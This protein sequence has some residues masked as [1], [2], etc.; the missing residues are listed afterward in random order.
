MK[1]LRLLVAD[2]Q[3]LMRAGICSLL[4]A[5]PDV[6]VVGEAS[7]GHEALRLIKTLQPDIVLMDAGM[8][9]MNG[10]E[11]TALTKKRFPCVKVIILSERANDEFLF[12]ALRAGAEGF[13]LKNDSVL[14]LHT[15][16]QS[17]ARGL[18]HLSPQVTKKVILGY[19]EGHQNGEEPVKRLTSRQ[20]EVLQ[21]IAEGHSTKDIAHLLAISVNT[22]ETHRLKLMESL[23]L[24]ELTGVVRYAVRMGLIKK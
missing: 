21:L 3:V 16:I 20:R 24:H 10:L 2:D 13:I 14:E 6:A 9:E 7:D 18:E 11:A 22:V 1:T 8:P 15:A 12:R 17:V 4:R 23:G 19:L 5:L